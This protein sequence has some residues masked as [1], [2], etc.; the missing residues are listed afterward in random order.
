MAKNIN[1]VQIYSVS[2]KR[3]TIKRQGRGSTEA[4]SRWRLFLT[5][6]QKYRRSFQ[7]QLKKTQR[8]QTEFITKEA[9]IRQNIHVHS[10]VRLIPNA[11]KEPIQKISAHVG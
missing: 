6:Y 5:I 8:Q 4:L 7:K 3:L 1:M 2:R 10:A 9:A 11:Q